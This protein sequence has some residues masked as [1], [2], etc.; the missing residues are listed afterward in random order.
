MS[1]LSSETTEYD[2]NSTGTLVEFDASHDSHIGW[3]L[4]ATKSADFVVEIRGRDVGWQQV[5]SYSGTTSVQDG[6]I[7]PA[8]ERV[9]IRNTS[10]ASGTADAVLGGA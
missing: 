6:L 3:F 5:E 4:S 2:L 9:R 8:P 10:T 7:M 1:E